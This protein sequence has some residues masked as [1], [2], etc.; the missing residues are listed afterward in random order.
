M[1]AVCHAGMVP[2]GGTIDSVRAVMLEVPEALL[3]ERRARGADRW[4][5]MWEGEL[6]MVPPPS[7]QHQAVGTKLVRVL[8]PV[9]EAQGLEARYE[10]GLFR[11]GVDDDYKVPDQLYA[12]PGLRS[13]R[14]FEGAASLVVEIL[15]PNDETYQK[16]DWYASVGVAEV[17]VIDPETRRVELFANRDGRMAPVEPVVIECLGVSAETVEGKLRLTWDGGTA[18]I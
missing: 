4:D 12:N 11:P 2:A 10:T 1:E 18:D 14:G 5:E 9:A 7:E 8:A 16:L 15:S 17:L 3:E 13:E 6:H